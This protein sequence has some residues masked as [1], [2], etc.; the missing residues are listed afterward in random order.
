MCTLND[1]L[2]TFNANINE[3]RIVPISF[4]SQTHH[5]E[6]LGKKRSWMSQTLF[7]RSSHSFV[8]GF[9]RAQLACYMHII[10]VC[11]GKMRAQKVVQSALNNETNM[12]NMDKNKKSKIIGS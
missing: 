11:L 8:V 12:L 5:F 4:L 6:L 10:S 2:L 9:P 7:L 3:L 1:F